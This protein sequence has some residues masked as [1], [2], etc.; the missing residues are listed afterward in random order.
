MYNVYLLWGKEQTYNFAVFVKLQ[1]ETSFMKVS[2]VWISKRERQ[3][4]ICIYPAG[5]YLHKLFELL[6]IELNLFENHPIT[7]VALKL[8]WPTIPRQPCW[9]DCRL[10]S[11][12]YTDSNAPYMSLPIKIIAIV[13]YF[14]LMCNC[15]SSKRNR[16]PYREAKLEFLHSNPI[17]SRSVH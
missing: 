9:V 14:T 10:I 5:Y 6:I 1:Y 8:C 13:L 11:T 17:S 2:E 12:F 16:C 4:I 7:D 15:T 3:Y